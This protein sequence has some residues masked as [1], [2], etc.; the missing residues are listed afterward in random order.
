MR[1]QSMFFKPRVG[2]ALADAKLQDVLSRFRF[3]FADKR[4][5]ARAAFGEDEF[6]TLRVVASQIRDRSL[7]QLDAWLL[8]FEAEATKRGTKVLWAEDHAEARRLV[9]EICERHDLKKA[10][11]SKSMVEAEAGVI[12]ML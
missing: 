10:I 1:S 3:G 5:A 7:A 6:E 8:R 12:A 4:A 9:L 2:G 11:K